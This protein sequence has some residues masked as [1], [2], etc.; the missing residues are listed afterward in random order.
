MSNPY[1]SRRAVHHGGAPDSAEGQVP[2]GTPEVEVGPEVGP[3]VDSKPIP[4]RLTRASRQ[5]RGRRS[6]S[7]WGIGVAVVSVVA[8]VALVF[9][10]FVL[11]RLA[12]PAVLAVEGPLD[13]IAVSGRQGST[14]V[15][16][17]SGPVDV[18]SAKL[19][20]E[21]RGVGR[22]ITEDSPV[23]VSVTAYDGKTGENI[24]PG[25]APNLILSTANEDNHGALLSRVLIGST[26]GSRLLLA[27]PLENGDTEIDVV[28]VLYTIASGPQSADASGPLSVSFTDM[29]PVVSHAPGDPPDGLVVQ[30]LNEG[31]GP[32]VESGDVVV[33]Q[34]LA[35]NWN[36]G[37]TVAS[38][39]AAG[40]PSMVS[41][42]DA[43]PGIRDALV[44]QRVGSRL[45]VTIPA[46]MATGADTLFVV[47]DILGAM[48]ASGTEATTDDLAGNAGQ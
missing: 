4:Q 17:T 27:R 20:V 39:W 45:A 14:P 38:T 37:Q 35:G 12:Q 48:P 46:E 16:T 5:S 24:N 18:A 9:G 2:D 40:S 32:Q 34:Y 13:A 1:P 19:R 30:I 33:A 42:E 29:G 15:V 7:W 6:R 21:F 28:D 10:G 11:S 36:D 26:E 31:T 8:V 47:I 43:M 25:G 3:E 23:L 22:E 44:D 41:L